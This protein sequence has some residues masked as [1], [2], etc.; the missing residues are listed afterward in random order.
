MA[1]KVLL[2]KQQ[3]AGCKIPDATDD[4]EGADKSKFFFFCSGTPQFCS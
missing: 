1:A 3:T 2:S 4:P